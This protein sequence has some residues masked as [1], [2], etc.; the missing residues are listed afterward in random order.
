MQIGSISRFWLCGV[1]LK[2]LK[3]PWRSSC[4]F[5]GVQFS[6]QGVG[7][8]RSNLQSHRGTTGWESQFLRRRFRNGRNSCVRSVGLGH[9]CAASFSTRRLV[10]A[11]W[12]ST[13]RLAAWKRVKNQHEVE[14]N[15]N[16][17][18]RREQCWRRF[19]LTLRTP[20]NPA[21]QLWCAYLRTVKQWSWWLLKTSHRRVPPNIHH[22][23]PFHSLTWQWRQNTGESCPRSITEYRLTSLTSYN[24]PRQLH[25]Q[26][27][28]SLPVFG[29]TCTR[30]VTVR[31]P[32]S[33]VVA[34][35]MRALHS[36]LQHSL[37]M[38]QR[39][40][41]LKIFLF[42]QKTLIVFG[43]HCTWARKR[44]ISNVYFETWRLDGPRKVFT[45]V[46]NLMQNL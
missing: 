17:W 14:R 11:E 19:I 35:S 21:I 41:W 7:H 39:S 18:R 15:K 43:Q 5:S 26:L 29:D 33:T 23:V 40:G 27:T 31:A 37:Q 34:V 46:Q 30:V 32:L 24:F 2:I 12:L 9:W 1:I 25:S 44:I 36:C 42:K 3:R 13:G 8:A 22:W 16:V 45:T 20:S 10:A 4:A 38:H 6:Y 28:T